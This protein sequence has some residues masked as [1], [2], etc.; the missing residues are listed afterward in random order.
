MRAKLDPDTLGIIL[1]PLFLEEFFPD[2]TR[3][4]CTGTM[5]SRHLYSPFSSPD[6][7]SL[8]HYN[9]LVRGQGA[10]VGQRGS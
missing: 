9:G 5:V 6:S 8:Q 3:R 10:Q 7:F 2:T 4:Y 1:L